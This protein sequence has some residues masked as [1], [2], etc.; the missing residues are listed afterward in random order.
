MYVPFNTEQESRWEEARF[1]KCA[2]RTKNS[3]FHPI[4]IRTL[5]GE[6]WILWCQSTFCTWFP[7]YHKTSNQVICIY[8]V[9]KILLLF[10]VGWHY[11]LLAFKAGQDSSKMARPLFVMFLWTRHQTIARQVYLELRDIGIENFKIL[12]MLLNY[13]YFVFT[14]T[15]GRFLLVSCRRKNSQGTIWMKQR[16]YSPLYRCQEG[17]FLFYRLL[18][19]FEL[20]NDQ[21]N[22][23][24]FS[25][26]YAVVARVLSK[27]A[28]PMQLWET[29]GK[30]SV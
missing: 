29:C 6:L 1:R 7:Y 26:T 30:G 14:R 24:K 13:L 21:Q 3:G 12:S 22:Q 20:E 19:L 27:L 10:C 28:E 8:L 16:F 11:L 15:L 25:R 5:P 18:C 2:K 4:W 9:K 17:N 23:Q